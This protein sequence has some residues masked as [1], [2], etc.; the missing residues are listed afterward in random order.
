MRDDRRNNRMVRLI[1][2]GG[3]QK[4]PGGKAELLIPALEKDCCSC[5]LDIKVKIKSDSNLTG[6]GVGESPLQ[7]AQGVQDHSSA[8][9]TM[10]RGG[11]RLGSAELAT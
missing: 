7:S 8:A 11:K 9:P 4:E 5:L 2:H 3:G 6:W 1:T 10:V